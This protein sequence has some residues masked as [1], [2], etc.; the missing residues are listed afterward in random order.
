MG[1]FPQA[2]LLSPYSRRNHLSTMAF[3]KVVKN[4]AYFMRFQVKYRRRREGK[5][6]Y[7]ARRRLI[8]QDKNKYN[9][10]KYRLVVRFT[11]KDV[12]AQIAYA[13]IEGDHIIAAAYS[14]ELPNYGV[15]VGLTNYAACYCTGLLLARRLLTKLNLADAYKGADEA[16]GEE[17]HVEE[18]ADGPRPFRANLD[19]GLV[20]TTTGARVFGVLKGAVDGGLS[21]P[22]SQRRFP[23]Y[24]PESKKLDAE[25]HRKYIFGGHVQEYMAYL[26]EEDAEAY[27]RQFSKYVAAGIN[28]EG[29]ESMYKKAHAN[30][31]KNPVHVAKPSTKEK[32]RKRY[33]RVKLSLA[34]RKDRVKQKKDAFRKANNIAA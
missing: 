5:T 7:Y 21:V 17:F 18:N 1:L 9:S 2:L 23:G 13:K 26:E 16:N 12:I 3:L 33:S 22:H 15:K 24:E 29:L 11:N 27:N 25:V 31:R 28:S 32:E 4:K 34:Q 10:P 19:V 30:I 14:H 20:R 6:D 8:N